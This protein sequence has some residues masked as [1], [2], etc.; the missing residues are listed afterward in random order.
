M[1]DLINWILEL[2]WSSPEKQNKIQN[3]EF[4]NKGY[5]YQTRE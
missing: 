1:R 5:K 3:N 2:L 4:K